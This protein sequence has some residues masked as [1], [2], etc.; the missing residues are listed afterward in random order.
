MQLKKFSP[1]TPS[2]RNLIRLNQA[3]LAKKPLLKNKIYGF[4]NNSGKNFTGQITTY[5]RGGGH[6]K[7]YRQI[8]FY[9]IQDSVG[10]I[11]SIEYDPFRTANIAS[12]Y[13][14]VQKKYFYIIAPKN[15]NVGDIVKSGKYA[16]P[17]LGNSLPLDKIP[18][19]SFI[20]NVSVKTNQKAQLSRAAGTFSQLIEKTSNSCR[21]KVSS[22]EQRYISSNC[23]ATIGIV[24]N[25]FLFLTT[26][27]KAGR[28][29]WLNR[30]PIVRGVAMNPI[31]HPHGG[32]EGKTSGGRSSVTPWGKP[33]KSGKTSRSKNTSIIIKRKNE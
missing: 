19:G 10:I 28:S 32:G 1:T 2:K 22:G 24:S 9:R 13:D 16:E 15:L 17:M 14:F 3:K 23:F 11:M 5:H 7:K 31:D 26:T 8:N 4:K 33:T 6:K 12:V 25:E 29:R 20:H 30:R 18:L 27:G 21:I